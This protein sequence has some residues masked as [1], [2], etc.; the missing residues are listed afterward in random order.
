MSELDV[1]T[2]ATGFTGRYITRRLLDAGRRVRTLTGHPD[3]PNPFGNRIEIVPYNFADPKA[4]GRNLEGVTTLYNT[5]WVRFPYGSQSYDNA[6]VNTRAL[7]RAAEEAD[8]KKF[9]HVSIAN[10]SEK[11]IADGRACLQAAEEA[12]GKKFLVNTSIASPLANY[13]LAYYWG[14]AFLEAALA[15]S[16]L[17]WAII[18]PT[19]VFGLEDILINNIAWMVRHLPVFGVPGSGDYKLQ[20][21]FVEDLAQIATDAAGKQENVTVDAAGPETYSFNGLVQLI[22]SKLGCRVRI[23]HVHPTLVYLMTR[24]LGLAVHDVILTR[25][26][27][28]GLMT[29]LLV[30]HQPPLGTTPLSQWLEQN[31]DRVG[32]RYASELDRH[33]R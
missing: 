19:V 15:Q 26:E 33:F 12:R 10:P 29:N 18:R 6:I 14:K 1:V 24:A 25:E 11:A 16:A 2:G 3:R 31:A 7:I 28:E 9:V 30:S 21:V 27:I 32:R 23:A 5:Y 22:A 8:V 17:S 13:R 20:P 4:L